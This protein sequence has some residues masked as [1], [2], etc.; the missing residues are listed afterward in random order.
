VKTM[1]LNLLMLLSVLAV[2]NATGPNNTPTPIWVGNVELSLGMSRAAVLAALKANYLL[3][4]SG[5]SG[6]VASDR[7]TSHAAAIL[8]FD[9]HGGLSRVQKNWTPVPDYTPGNPA[10]ERVSAIAFAQALYKLAEQ[11]PDENGRKL[12]SC[13]LSVSERLPVGPHAWLV[14]PGKPDIDIREVDLTCT[15]ETIQIYIDQ[16]TEATRATASTLGIEKVL[17]YES[18]DALESK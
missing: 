10:V 12:H 15:R 1:F 6:W 11:M 5:Q 18:V 13:S 14:H 4:K 8:S 2:S 17:L 7:R 16:P 3:T 9:E